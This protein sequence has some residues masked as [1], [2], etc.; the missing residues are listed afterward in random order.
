MST[1]K[2]NINSIQIINEFFRF[3]ENLE[4]HPMSRLYTLNTLQISMK[5]SFTDK[6]SSIER[7]YDKYHLIS[8]LTT[9]RQYINKK[10]IFHPEKLLEAASTHF[11][12]NKS[13]TDFL[14]E[15]SRIL[16]TKLSL[17]QGMMV[18]K[19]NGS[20]LIDENPYHEI[21]AARL[22]SGAIHSER[23]IVP[24]AGSIEEGLADSHPLAIETLDYLL[25][26]YS[27]AIL[28]NIYSARRHLADL[29]DKNRHLAIS[30]RVE[31]F[32][33]RLNS[34]ISNSNT[35]SNK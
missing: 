19:S 32:I 2:K 15:S 10:E 35:N 16:E 5:F 21:V 18:N 14:Q 29:S 13:I 31:G 20:L 33:D 8:F 24:R 23:N 28:S 27:T 25:C 6:D 22:Y 12:P 17:P 26:S 11:G 7:S 4:D 34:H 3:C 9:I 30:P 1:S